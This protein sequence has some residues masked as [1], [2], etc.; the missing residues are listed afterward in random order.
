MRIAI[1][2]ASNDGYFASLQHLIRSLDGIHRLGDFSIR[3]FDVGLTAAQRSELE[4]AGHT[5]MNPG[6]DVDVSPWKG[7]PEWFKAMTA[8]PFLPNYVNH[9]DVIVWLDADIWV[10]DQNMLW[11]PFCFRGPAGLE[12]PNRGDACQLRI[13]S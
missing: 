8:R 1:V 9:A 11:K 10:Q 12:R 5:V 4:A 3:V 2:T 13:V 7:V 6:W